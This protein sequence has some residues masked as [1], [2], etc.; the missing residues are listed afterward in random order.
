VG[1][2]EKLQW[3][4]AF[5]GFPIGKIGDAVTADELENAVKEAEDLHLRCIYLLV[6]ADDHEFLESARKCGFFMYD[7]RIELSR[8]VSGNLSINE[9]L[10]PASV[11]DLRTV[12]DLANTSFTNTRF[13]TDKNFPRDRVCK[14]YG[15]W[16]CKGLQEGL[17]YTT[18]VTE[19]LTGF[20][21]CH[22]D[23][24]SSV[25]SIV[26]I[27]VNPKFAKS[28]VGSLLVAG[29]GS[30]FASASLLSSKVITQGNNVTAQRLYQAHG[31]RT[32][33]V[34]LWLHRWI[35]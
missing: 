19:D 4:S 7:I 33:N 25:G 34:G 11:E 1:Y 22:I 13:F 29:A 28:G 8:A 27:A 9:T 21:V 30:V 23:R 2:V 24:V 3:D 5:F 10:R 14:L 20:V 31:Y 16:V 26:L 6:P 18:L 15:E 32:S 35:K 12:C 17:G